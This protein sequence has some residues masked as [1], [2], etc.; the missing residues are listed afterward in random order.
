MKLLEHN[1]IVASTTIANEYQRFVNVQHGTVSVHSWEQRIKEMHALPQSGQSGPFKYSGKPLAT[2]TGIVGSAHSVEKSK[3]AELRWKLLTRSGGRF[4]TTVLIGYLL[5]YH[6]FFCHWCL[7][8]QIEVMHCCVSSRGTY[9]VM[10]CYTTMAALSVA[11]VPSK[12]LALCALSAFKKCVNQE[13]IAPSRYARFLQYRHASRS[14]TSLIKLA[15]NNGI[16][17]TK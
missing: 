12:W 13:G 5:V 1:P 11:T 10:T 7:W 14:F 3:E 2:G 16:G 15:D 8:H 9:L 6:S 17:C 4:P